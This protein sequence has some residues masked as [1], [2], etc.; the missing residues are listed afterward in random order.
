MNTHTFWVY[1]FVNKKGPEGS[2]FSHSHYL[3]F[4]VHD[5]FFGKY[6]LNLIQSEGSV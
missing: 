2:L 1:I 3:E 4:K 5:P 6:K